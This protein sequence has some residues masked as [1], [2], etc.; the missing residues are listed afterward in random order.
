MTKQVVRSMDESVTAKT[1]LCSLTWLQA[2]QQLYESISLTE[3]FQEAVK[4]FSLADEFGLY[5]CL[6]VKG[7]TYVKIVQ[8][9]QELGV[10]LCLFNA[11]LQQVINHQQEQRDPNREGS[12]L[13]SFKAN[14]EAD[15]ENKNQSAQQRRK[16]NCQDITLLECLFLALV[17]F[18]MTGEHMDFSSTATLCTGSNFSDGGI[19]NVHAS[20]DFDG[21]V[22][23]VGSREVNDHDGRNRARSVI[24][25]LRGLVD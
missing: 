1:P 20:F 23:F 3:V 24:S 15:E 8:A 9:Y 16:Q 7:L 6:M 11:D 13:V 19:P 17:Y 12:Y 18:L 2:T 5:K 14:V 22:V 10:T 4:H 21:L 25:L